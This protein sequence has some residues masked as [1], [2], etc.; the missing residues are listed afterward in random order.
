MSYDLLDVHLGIP[1]ERTFEGW[2]VGQ[3]QA[4]FAAIGKNALVFDVSPDDEADWP[5]DEALSASGKVVGLQF[6]QP[7]LCVHRVKTIDHVVLIHMRR[8]V[9]ERAEG[10]RKSTRLNSS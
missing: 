4:Y 9:T 10:D 1:Q 8:R 2:I 3:I 5:A 7:H 6:K